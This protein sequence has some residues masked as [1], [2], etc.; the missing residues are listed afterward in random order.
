MWF[1]LYRPRYTALLII[2]NIPLFIYYEMTL[3]IDGI[4][5]CE[6]FIQYTTI[7]IGADTGY[8]KGGVWLTVNY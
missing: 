6:L 1:I 4:C 5:P 8:W 3:N 2:K 7:Y